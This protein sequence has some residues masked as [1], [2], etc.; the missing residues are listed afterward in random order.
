MSTNT[1]APAPAT[2]AHLHHLLDA[3]QALAATYRGRMSN[4]L[5]M[6]QQALLELGVSAERL[7][8][9][10]EAHEAGLEPCTAARPA[11]VVLERDLGRVDSD[12][13]W[14]AHFARRIAELGAPQALREA[15]AL[16]LPGAGAIAFH[17]LI[18]TAHGALAGHEG[19]LASG[20]AHWASQF[21]PLADAGGSP[22]SLAE[23]AEAL[24]QLPRPTYPAGSF[25]ADRMQAWR[26]GHRWPDPV[27]RR[28][29]ERAIPF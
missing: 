15:L 17:G 3:G 12:A 19:E 14:R 20:L 29:V 24:L 27:W 13:A 23:W 18:R 26:L 4:H 16:L 11:R 21:M 22:M 1:T 6:A 25:I 7:H 8:A 28:A 9:F 10:T 2:L 5:P